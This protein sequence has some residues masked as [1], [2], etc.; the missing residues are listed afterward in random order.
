[1]I[2]SILSVACWS[3][4]ESLI[5]FAR[6]VD[7]MNEIPRLPSSSV[8]KVLLRIANTAFKTRM[9]VCIFSDRILI[10]SHASVYEFYPTKRKT[11]SLQC[12]SRRHLTSCLISCNS[13][14]LD[15]FVV[16]PPKKMFQS[17]NLQNMMSYGHSYGTR[18]CTVIR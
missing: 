9:I 18:N 2:N 4:I 11:V 10:S 1:M 3:L 16:S 17:K 6:T 8:T 7:L 13:S 14:P 12:I 5:N 15:V